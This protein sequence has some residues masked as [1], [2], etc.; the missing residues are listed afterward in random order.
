MSSG[1]N[2]TGFRSWRFWARGDRKGHMACGIGRDSSDG[3]GRPY[4]FL[5]IGIGPLPG[6]EDRWDLLPW[7]LEDLWGG[8]EYFAAK[9]HKDVEAVK[10][11]LQRLRPPH[12]RWSEWE[13]SENAT[14]RGGAF[15]EGDVRDD[16]IREMESGT[17]RL[18]EQGDLFVKLEAKT[19]QDQSARINLWHF[20][21]RSKL[22]ALPNAVFVGGGPDQAYLAVFTRALAPA[23]FVRLWSV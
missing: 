9:R 13:M 21:L 19:F 12:V 16:V 10:D 17:V 23:D 7:A 5:S 3:L 2:G 15:G 4:P 8:F 1:H 11:G 22:G 20:R 18:R 6:W 14:R